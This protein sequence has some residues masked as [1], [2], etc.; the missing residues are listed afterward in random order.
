MY[1]NPTFYVTVDEEESEC[2]RQNTGI[3]Q[4]CP[5]PPYLIILVMDRLFEIIP[6]V[7]K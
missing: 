1:S 3:R 5:L 7:A 4:G 6:E 2:A